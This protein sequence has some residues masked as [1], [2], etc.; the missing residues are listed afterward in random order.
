MLHN[1][2]NVFP[3]EQLSVEMVCNVKIKQ[4]VRHITE[5]N[6]IDEFHQA[7]LKINKYTALKSQSASSVS[8]LALFFL[9]ILSQLPAYQLVHSR[10]SSRKGQFQALYVS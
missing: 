3:L 9:N 7:T 10:K 4:K 1:Y 5:R 8:S 2:G 6:I